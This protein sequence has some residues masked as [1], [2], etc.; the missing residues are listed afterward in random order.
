MFPLESV[1]SHDRTILHCLCMSQS[2]P[3][4]II[5]KYIFLGIDVKDKDGNVPLHFCNRKWKQ[6]CY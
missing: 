2:V 6:E 4:E 3:M 5:Q 1:D